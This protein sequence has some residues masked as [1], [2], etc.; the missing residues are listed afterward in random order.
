MP[1]ED[2]D[3]AT[4]DRIHAGLKRLAAELEAKNRAAFDPP[5]PDPD[6]VH[7]LT[8]DETVI[9]TAE[10]KLKRWEAEPLPKLKLGQRS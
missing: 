6:T 5:Q 3:P 10:A 9:L 4:A 1:P 8:E 7:G 2:M